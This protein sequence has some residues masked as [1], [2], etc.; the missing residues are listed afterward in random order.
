MNFRD[1]AVQWVRTFEDS[2]TSVF[3]AQNERQQIVGYTSAGRAT[4]GQIPFDSEVYTLY[5][6]SQYR[7]RGL[8]NRLLRAAADKLQSE[9]GKSLVI[10]VLKGNLAVEFYL[11]MGGSVVAEKTTMLG[12]RE[13][14]EI[15]FG[16]PDIT[17]VGH[18]PFAYTRTHGTA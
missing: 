16:W 18:D 17:Q 9:G 2:R 3:V 1:A 11:K 7:H 4:S 14:K 10:W 5:V 12:G 6:L 8:G 15:A 13:Y